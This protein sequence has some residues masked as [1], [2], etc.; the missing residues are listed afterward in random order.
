M[1]YLKKI[2]NIK[3]YLTAKCGIPV[4]ISEGLIPLRALG[5]FFAL[6]SEAGRGQVGRGIARRGDAG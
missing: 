6:S 2:R 4:R 1:F 5:V 3:F